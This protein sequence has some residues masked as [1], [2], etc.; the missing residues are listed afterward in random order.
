MIVNGIALADTVL[1]TEDWQRHETGVA[2]SAEA[3]ASLLTHIGKYVPQNQW[4]PWE[5]RTGM[6]EGRDGLVGLLWWVEGEGSA[7]ADS[8]DG[9]M[10]AIET[11]ERGRRG[12]GGMWEGRVGGWVGKGRPGGWERKLGGRREPKRERRS[13]THGTIGAF[14]SRRLAVYN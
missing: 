14:R 7:E 11:P 12:E 9:K 3:F 10:W 13:R 1:M 4:G 5:K 8:E 6:F 2:T